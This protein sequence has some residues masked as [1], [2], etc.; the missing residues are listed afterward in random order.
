MCRACRDLADRPVQW[1]T[2]R[3]MDAVK[4][5]AQEV[6]KV[7]TYDDFAQGD[8]QLPSRS[9][10]MKL[11]GLNRFLEAAGMPTRR[12]RA[13]WSNARYSDAELLAPLLAHYRISGEAPAANE[14]ERAKRFPSPNGLKGRFGSWNRALSAAG[15]P[16]R[17][18]GEHRDTTR[19]AARI[20]S[21]SQPADGDGRSERS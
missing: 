20:P 18:S 12:R 4:S 19:G 17:R 2:E 1:T 10:I 3:V 5:I 16:T 6:G 8:P 13:D 11:G 21:E 9:T 15:I 7:P 14:W